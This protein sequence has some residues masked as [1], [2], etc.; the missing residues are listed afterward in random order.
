MSKEDDQYDISK[1]TDK[2]LYNILDLNN[3]SDREL[4][5]RIIHLINKYASMHNDSGYKLAIFFQ[6]MYYHFFDTDAEAELDTETKEGFTN[7]ANP[8]AVTITSA[9]NSEPKNT[10]IGNEL[11][12]TQTGQSATSAD[13]ITTTNFNY[14]LD[15]FGMNPLLKQT[16]TRIISIDSQYRQNKLNSL[17]TNFTL[18]LS[19]P[20]KD[21]VSLTLETVTI[22]FSWYTISKSYG[23]NFF[24]IKGRSDEINTNTYNGYYDYKIEIPPGNYVL[25]STKTNYICSAIQKSITDLSNTYSDTNFGTTN[26]LYNQSTIKSSI[27]LD[28]QL[29]YNETSFKVDFSNSIINNQFGFYKDEYTPYTILS[30]N[31]AITNDRKIVYWL[32][33]SNNYFNVVQYDYDSTSTDPQY[34]YNNIITTIPIQIDLPDGSYSYINLYTAI[35]RAIQSSSFLDISYSRLELISDITNTEYF[36]MNIKLNRYKVKPV[37]NSKVAVIFP[38]H[39]TTLW[40]SPNSCFY[41]K[42]KINE[43][44]VI[45]AETP[46]VPSSIIVDNWTYISFICKSPSIYGSTSDFSLNDIV[47][48]IDSKE[49]LQNEFIT[50][51]NSLWSLY[52]NTFNTNMKASID[53]NDRFN[54]NIDILKQFDTDA[55]SIYIDPS[56]VLTQIFEISSGYFN[57]SDLSLINYEFKGIAGDINNSVVTNTR[58]I[59]SYYPNRTKNLGNKNDISYNISVSTN[60]YADWRALL[61]EINYQLINFKTTDSNQQFTLK[62]S[63]LDQSGNN[64]TLKMNIIYAL[65]EDNYSVYFYDYNEGTTNIEISNIINSWSTLKIDFSYNINTLPYDA[66]G[67]SRILIGESIELSPVYVTPLNNTFY[68]TPYSSIGGVYHESNHFKITIPITDSNNN[69]INYSTNRLINTINDIFSKD[70]RLV[71]SRIIPYIKDNH[72]YVKLLLNI[73]IIYTTDDYDIVFYDAISYINCYAGATSVRNTTWDSTLGWILGFHDY[74]SYSLTKDKQTDN[75]YYEESTTGSYFYNSQSGIFSSQIKNTIITLTG[76]T[77][78]TTNLYNYFLLVLDDYIQNHLNDGLVCITN[79]ETAIPVPTYSTNNAD[80]VC[81]PI[82]NTAIIVSTVNRDGLTQKQL[83]AANQ[84]VISKPRDNYIYTRSPNVHDVFGII[85][86]APPTQL[87]GTSYTVNGGNLQNHQRLYFGPVNISRLLIQLKTDKG[88]ILDLNGSN[89]SFSLVCEQLYRNS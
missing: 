58:K 80:N 64:I 19:E 53:T 14:K 73:N 7:E 49:Y 61:I 22:P 33:S 35:N 66:T 55:W 88:D 44:N 86:A 56:S 31:R 81:D 60:Q 32:D 62:N 84:A 18:N 54:L 65:T 41:F 78:T 79:N 59:L 38:D 46:S 71:G 82:T 16:V 68:I 85:S 29:A 36:K 25:D 52:P 10:Q 40:T 28:I 17:T 48:K 39:D 76:D 20:L 89:W 13:I 43:T 4:E 2:E 6:N 1:Y 15:K 37:P 72:L 11:R 42:N 83:Y 26:V 50:K 75:S 51:L 12:N 47:L 70:S 24:I 87:P 30:N 74:T 21:V 77:G 63:I 45:Y 34:L 57:L 23:S 8:S 5:A 67:T 3:P 69:I 9:A 27:T